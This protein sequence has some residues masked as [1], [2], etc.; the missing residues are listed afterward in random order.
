MGKKKV[1]ESF[2]RSK[3]K[4]QR[5]LRLKSIK[6]EKKKQQNNREFF[7]L[8]QQENIDKLST[9]EKLEAM[10]QLY[11]I[12]ISYPESN[13]DK[14]SLMLVFLKDNS[15]TV[16]SKAVEYLKYIF[17]ES[18]PLYRIN[19]FQNNKQK[20]SKEVKKTHIQEKNLL[21][22]Y[23]QFIDDVKLLDQSFN[24]KKEC[25]ELRKK[26]CTVLSELFEKFYYFNYEKKLYGYL[27]DKLSDSNN[28]IKKQAYICLYN[29]LSKVDNSKSMFELKFEIIKRIINSIN[30]KNHKRFDENVMDLFT[31]HRMIFPDYVKENENIK[32]KIDLSDLKYAGPSAS[33]S[34]N[35]H[36]YIKAQKQLKEFNKEKSKI[37]KSMQKDMNEIEKKDDSKM[38]YFCNLKIL[39]KIL[40]LF[41]E[42]LKNF[43]ESELVGGVFNGIST[44]CENINVEI[45]IDL[46]KCIYEN[47]KYLIKNKKLS[48]ALL[49]LRANLN[50][51]KKL[52]KEIVSVEDS[53]L[54]TSSYQIICFYINDKNNKITKDDL[55]IIFEVIEMILL[56]NRMYSID[57]SAA[58]IKRLTMLCEMNNNENYVIGLL[59]LIKRVLSKYPSLGFL[60]DSNEADF[61]NFDYKNTSE[62]S[63]CNSKL[64]NIIKELNNIQNKFNSNK[65]IKKLIEYI[66]KEQKNNLELSSLNYYDYL[67]K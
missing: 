3:I 63:L 60:V 1:K 12:L 54:I 15:I 21:L 17:I 42:I 11:K 34:T 2:H 20:E 55:Y 36:D 26:F 28:D 9:K 48:L 66:L 49:G 51:A 16:I 24:N 57:T 67:L 52:T 38:I 61:D 37:I 44:L 39:K 47:I 64:T 14:F 22:N 35:K 6:K 58:I 56:K 46:Q 8:F 19:E 59:L 50:I 23:G 33:T 65:T 10:N 43:Q 53:Y 7:T 40:L 30:N 18:I 29:V 32:N 5:I 62:P 4:E 27:V 13:S 41:F 25:I 45:L 31:A